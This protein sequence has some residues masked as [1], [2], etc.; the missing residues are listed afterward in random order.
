M[1]TNSQTSQERRKDERSAACCF[2]LVTKSADS[3][4]VQGWWGHF[5]KR[6]QLVFLLSGPLTSYSR[7][8]QPEP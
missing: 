7:L 8:S 3:V 5:V 6:R 4:C 2:S 1:L